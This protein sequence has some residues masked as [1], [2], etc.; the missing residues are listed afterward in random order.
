MYKNNCLLDVQKKFCLFN[1]SRKLFFSFLENINHQHVYTV[2]ESIHV[3][4]KNDT[5]GYCVR[6][7]R[8]QISMRKCFQETEYIESHLLPFGD[9][10]STFFFG[11]N[12]LI[13]IR[14]NPFTWLDKQENENLHDNSGESEH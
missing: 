6:I 8:V 9:I 11:V 1:L 4:S 13:Y 12:I 5:S 14:Q 2:E 7:W 3:I 10:I